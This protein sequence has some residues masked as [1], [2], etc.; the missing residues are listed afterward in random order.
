VLWAVQVSDKF[1]PQRPRKKLFTFAADHGVTAEGV[2]AY[3]K[4][5]TAQMVHNFLK[6]GAAI[7][8]LARHT[9]VELRIIDMGV[10][11]DFGGN[12]TLIRKK[13]NYGTQNMAR[14]PAMSRDEAISS[15]LVGIQ[16]AQEAAQCGSMTLLGTGDMGIGNTT[17]SSAITAVLTGAPVEVVTGRGTGLG[18]E[19]LAHKRQV[20]QMALDCNGPNRDD[21]IDVLQKIG[22]FEIGGIV[23]LILGGA[24]ERM[25]IVIDGFISTAAALIA[26]ALKPEVKPYLLAAHKSAEPGHQIALQTLGLSALLSFDMR[27][28]E[29]S[30]AALGM[31]IVDAAIR[32]A[33]EMA[34]FDQ[35]GV[36]QQGS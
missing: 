17:P 32:T 14:G 23:G 22:G 13:I 26:V 31:N 24:S 4:V 5:V 3:P 16:L 1:P 36:S 27:L 35:A 33:I 2:S 29:G 11:Y 7:N 28:G 6:G 9:G 19:A 30:G 21:P 18:D 20:I 10:D 12:P 34:S 25:P 8:V 15:I